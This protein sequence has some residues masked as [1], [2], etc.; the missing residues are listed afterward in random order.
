MEGE[1]NEVIS[2]SAEEV[3]TSD[4]AAVVPQSETQNDSQATEEPAPPPAEEEVVVTHEAP[5]EV[6][7]EEQP[8]EAP[9]PAVAPTDSP[10]EKETDH[11]SAEPAPSDPDAVEPEVVGASDKVEGDASKVEGVEEPAVE[12]LPTPETTAEAP[13]VATDP[14]DHA[15]E[16]APVLTPLDVSHDAA[17][18]VQGGG[19]DVIKKDRKPEDFIL[20]IDLDKEWPRVSQ[21]GSGSYSHQNE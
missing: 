3:L 16:A 12:D 7:T 17:Q 5:V 19:G 4:H 1:E 20:P 6:K 10:V 13:V 18:V 21:S 15:E 8:A 14:A 2:D 11:E 9:P